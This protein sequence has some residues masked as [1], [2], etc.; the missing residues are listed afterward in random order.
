M[1]RIL[2]FGLN[3][4]NKITSREQI[5]R[6]QIAS[7]YC[8][9]WVYANIPGAGINSWF[10]AVDRGPERNERTKRNVLNSVRNTWFG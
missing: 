5:R 3:P 10:E 2:A 6:R 7:R 4:G 1:I 9:T 8:C